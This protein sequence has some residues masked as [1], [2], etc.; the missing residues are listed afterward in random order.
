[1]TWELLPC[2]VMRLASQLHCLWSE[3][4][5]IP[6]RGARGRFLQ[7]VG[8]SAGVG[9]GSLCDG[10]TRPQPTSPFVGIPQ[11]R[12]LRAAPTG[13]LRSRRRKRSGRI[14]SALARRSARV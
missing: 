13:A 6:L 3:R 8:S 1:M 9:V 4:G 14:S 12:R 11:E 10:A 5:S 7:K 2:L